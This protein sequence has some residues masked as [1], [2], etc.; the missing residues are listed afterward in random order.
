MPLDSL[1]LKL[2]V[3]AKED[4]KGAV[5]AAALQDIIAASVKIVGNALIE[6]LT[7]KVPGKSYVMATL[8]ARK[9]RPINQAKFAP[10]IPLVEMFE[11]VSGMPAPDDLIRLDRALYT[12]AMSYHSQSISL[13]MAT[14][15]RPEHSLRF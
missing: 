5:T 15:N 13:R 3:A 10:E 11:V 7:S 14:K 1:Y 12:A 2:A 4:L 9:S 6:P 8:G